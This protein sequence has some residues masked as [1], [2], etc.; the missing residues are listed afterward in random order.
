MDNL[1]PSTRKYRTLGLLGVC[2]QIYAETAVLPF[3]TGIFLLEDETYDWMWLLYLARAQ[4]QAI[5]TIHLDD[6]GSSWDCCSFGWTLTLKKILPKLP[7]LKQVHVLNGLVRSRHENRMRRALDK[8]SQRE[9]KLKELIKDLAKDVE[10]TFERKSM[11]RR[12]CTLRSLRRGS[13]F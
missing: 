11:S 8:A 5:T 3:Q 1:R 9:N 10:I 12:A 13:S 2:S 6:Q 4:L 7:G